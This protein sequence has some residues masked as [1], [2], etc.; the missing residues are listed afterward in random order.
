MFTKWVCENLSLKVVSDK[1]YEP[2]KVSDIKLGDKLLDF[3]NEHVQITNILETEFTGK[4]YTI[5][6][7]DFSSKNS[8]KL[9]TCDENNQMIAF[10]MHPH[11]FS[12]NKLKVP[13]CNE[14]AILLNKKNIKFQSC[15]QFPCFKFH[16]ILIDE[17]DTEIHALVDDLKFIEISYPIK[18]LVENFEIKEFFDNLRIIKSTTK[19]KSIVQA[20]PLLNSISLYIGYWLGDGYKRSTA[21]VTV[22]PLELE[23]Y[24]IDMLNVINITIQKV[25]NSNFCN[26]FNRSM[27]KELLPNPGEFAQ[28]KLKVKVLEPRDNVMSNGNIVH[29]QLPQSLF[30]FVKANNGNRLSSKNFLLEEM[31]KLNLLDEKYR[32]IPSQIFKS[33]DEVKKK[34][35]AGLILSN[36]Y[37]H[38]NNDS[39]T[40]GQSTFEHSSIVEDLQK[41]L[42]RLGINTRGIFESNNKFGSITKT[43]NFDD[44]ENIF[45]EYLFYKRKKRTSSTRTI[46]RDRTK[47]RLKKF[48]INEVD[49]TKLKFRKITTDKPF[50][51]LANS[52]PL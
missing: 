48:T 37:L 36:G 31:K 38:K 20:E 52:A 51:Q 18:N 19:E 2:T 35:V 13:C 1:Y 41:I 10:M 8:T 39:Y 25:N 15:S 43:V 11:F 44:N 7:T 26:V 30:W 6:F 23:E 47:Q 22:D 5:E 40:F 29:G 16:D 28:L 21:I 49:S 14:I 50:I 3:N 17:N 32:G 4:S 45:Q 33:S 27:I 12:N 24:L 46:N 9:I 34:V 42:E